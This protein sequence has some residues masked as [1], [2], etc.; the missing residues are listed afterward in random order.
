MLFYNPLIVFLMNFI[1]DVIRIYDERLDW[2]LVGEWVTELN[3]RLRNDG[4]F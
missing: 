3:P 1:E 4:N 2:E